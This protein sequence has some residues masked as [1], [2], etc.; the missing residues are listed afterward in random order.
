MIING[1]I[2]IT[3]TASRQVINIGGVIGHA[4]TTQLSKA[5]SYVDISNE[6]N[7]T[8]HV[9][10]LVG[11]SWDGGSISQCMYFG[12]ID[13]HDT[14]DSIGGIVGYTNTTSI[15]YCAN[16]GSVKTDYNA[17]YVGGILGYINNT[18]GSVRNCYNYGEVQNG[19]R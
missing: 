14:G 19:R 4:E 6:N 17:G 9:G 5:F 1:K 15:S 2:L 11:G 7:E 10:G 8:T 3:G 18:G 16:H 13:L 12:S